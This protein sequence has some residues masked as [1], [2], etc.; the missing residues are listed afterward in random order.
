MGGGGEMFSAILILLITEFSICLTWGWVERTKS[1]VFI[2]FFLKYNNKKTHHTF[3]TR[4]LLHSNENLLFKVQAEK[5]ALE[6][7]LT[8][9]EKE[10][11][12]LNENC[13][14]YRKDL[15]ILEEQLR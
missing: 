10:K 15:N 8:N 4:L 1:I 7:Y 5:E 2:V 3:K 9:C 14:S 11:E 12:K 13:I 6:K